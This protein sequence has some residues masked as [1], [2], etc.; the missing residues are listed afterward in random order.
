MFIETSPPRVNGDNALLLSPEHGSSTNDVCLNFYYHM[1]GPNVGR[2]NVKVNKY[3]PIFENLQ[4]CI[5][6]FLC[7]K[8]VL[9]YVMN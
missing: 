5:G 9:I 6:V 2:L 7:L 8:N 3:L 1:F 4:S